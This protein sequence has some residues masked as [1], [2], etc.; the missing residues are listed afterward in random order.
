AQ[1]K[2]RGFLLGVISNVGSSLDT[3]LPGVDLTIFDNITLSFKAGVAKPDSLIFQA[4]LEKS[5]SKPEEV[6]FIDDREVNL[7]GANM[8]GMET[9]LYEDFESTKKAVEDLI[10]R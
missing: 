1:L 7:E 6:I 2:D 4:H 3:F 10:K 9:L 8:I 5:G